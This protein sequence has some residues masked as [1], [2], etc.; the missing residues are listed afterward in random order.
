MVKMFTTSSVTSVFQAGQYMR[1]WKPTIQFPRAFHLALTLTTLI[2]GLSYSLMFVF[3]LLLH[4]HTHG[5]RLI[6]CTASPT[7]GSTARP[8]SYK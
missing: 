8:P 1:A 6:Y 5:L 3:I 7:Y 4:F 2:L